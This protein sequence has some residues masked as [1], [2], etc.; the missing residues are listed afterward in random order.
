MSRKPFVRMLALVAT[1]AAASL[2]P[3]AVRAGSGAHNSGHASIPSG[4]GS[5]SGTSGTNRDAADHS[6]SV[7]AHPMG[8]SYRCYRACMA[9]PAGGGMARFCKASCSR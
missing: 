4:G 5:I 8:F 2:A 3:A 7:G 6:K 1:V 9:G